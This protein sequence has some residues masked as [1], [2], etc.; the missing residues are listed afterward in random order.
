MIKELEAVKKRLEER[1]EDMNLE[2][3]ALLKR[4]EFKESANKDQLKK[5]T[6]KYNQ[7]EVERSK[8]TQDYNNLLS[9]MEANQRKAQLATK[10]RERL[11]SEEKSKLNKKIEQMNKTIASL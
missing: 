8:A 5:M 11:F 10:E 3:A 6:D 2:T 4:I 9:Q 1:L 7:C